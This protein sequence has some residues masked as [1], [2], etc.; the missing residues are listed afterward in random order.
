MNQIPFCVFSVDS[1]L[2]HTHTHMLKGTGYC[3]NTKCELGSVRS[4]VWKEAR[5]A[6]GRSLNVFLQ[7]MGNHRKV[8]SW[9]SVL[10]KENLAV[11][12]KCMQ[13][14][15]RG[16]YNGLRQDPMIA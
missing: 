15:L 1:I 5:Y 7:V 14:Q 10:F 6:V 8:L 2:G 9:S 11:V 3:E 4:E 12:E 16:C 13:H